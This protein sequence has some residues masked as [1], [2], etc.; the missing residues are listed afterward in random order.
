MNPIVREQQNNRTISALVL[1]ML[2]VLCHPAISM[3]AVQGF[4]QVPSNSTVI[5]GWVYLLGGLM[6]LAIISLWA[7]SRKRQQKK[8]QII[9]KQAALLKQQEEELNEM[10]IFKRSV[11]KL[12][13]HDLKKPLDVIIGMSENYRLK[14]SGLVMRSVMSNILDIE[15]MKQAELKPVFQVIQLSALVEGIQQYLEP[16]LKTNKQHVE[17]SIAEELQVKGDPFLLFR[18]LENLL[19]EVAEYS[20]SGS[21]IKIQATRTGRTA[22]ITIRSNLK[23]TSKKQLNAIIENT[24]TAGDTGSSD[25]SLELG[26]SYCKRAL[27]LHER[28]ISLESTEEGETVLRFSLP[29]NEELS[30]DAKPIETQQPVLCQ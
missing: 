26:L 12:I 2:Y 3:G 4:Q 1:L 19:S 9:S 28:D 18:T 29:V 13:A 30:N 24:D 10:K 15:R 5:P 20:P 17:I 25:S 8:D 23:G 21:V 14:K 6:L 11:M 7:F 27:H 16:I 22:G